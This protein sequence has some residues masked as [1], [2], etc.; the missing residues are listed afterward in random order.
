MLVCVQLSVR[1][2]Q[3]FICCVGTTIYSQWWTH[4]TSTFV[5]LQPT[6]GLGRRIV[7]VSRLHTHTHTRARARTHTLSDSFCTSDKPVA[8]SAI[9]TTHKKHKR[10][11]SVPSA[12][13]EPAI[14]TS[15][16]CSLY[17]R[18]HSH[19]G[20]RGC[21]ITKPYFFFVQNKVVILNMEKPYIV[22]WAGIAQ[23]V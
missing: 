18:L 23:S 20:R 11:N 22:L 6:P 5:A 19:R 16:G 21:T 13:F 10:R 1:V 7:E 4:D 14:P 3:L 8:N 17:L 12:G 15:D 2:Q 9:Y